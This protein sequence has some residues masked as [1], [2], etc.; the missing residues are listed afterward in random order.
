[1]L[2]IGLALVVAAAIVLLISADAGSMI[3]LTQNQTAQLVPLVI[4]LIV[5]AG[6]LFARRH[7]AAELVGGLMLWMG[8]FAAVMVGY[9]YRDDILGVVSRVT[10]ELRPGMAMVDSNTGT[11]TFRRGLGGHFEVNSNINGHVTPMIFDTGASAVVLTVEDAQAAGI[12]TTGLRYTVPV[13]TANGRGMAA[14]TRLEMLEV[15]GIV[16]RNVTAFVTEAG[17]MDTS[18]LGMTFLETLSRYSVSQNALELVD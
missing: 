18:L 11:A 10:G 3:G 12:D 7:R 1:M 2:F 17:A 8:I 15:G 9:S 6:G 16:R 13:S 14:R 5:F 4:I